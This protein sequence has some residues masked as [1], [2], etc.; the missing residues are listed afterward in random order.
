MKKC[1]S[2]GETKPL[3]D[4]YKNSSAKDGHSYWCRNCT[5]RRNKVYRKRHPE[6]NKRS[7]RQKRLDPNS[8]EWGYW[9]RTHYDIILDEYNAMLADQG[10]VCAICGRTQEENGKRLSVDHDH[11]TGAVRGLLCKSCNS[12]LAMFQDSPEIFHSAADYLRRKVE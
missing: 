10:G 3:S 4:Y 1:P 7:R 9:I 12:G 11:E 5:R 2:C 6:K 8:G